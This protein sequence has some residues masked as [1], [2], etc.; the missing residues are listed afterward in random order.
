MTQSEQTTPASSLI[1][2]VEEKLN[3]N[4]SSGN[5]DT[6]GQAKEMKDREK[7]QSGKK[8]CG[9]QQQDKFI[10]FYGNNLLLSIKKAKNKHS[11]ETLTWL[12]N[13][14][15]RPIRYWQYFN[16]CCC[17]SYFFFTLSWPSEAYLIYVAW[18]RFG[19]GCLLLIYAFIT[20]IT[21]LSLF[22]VQWGNSTFFSQQ[23]KSDMSI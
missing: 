10:L 3:P 20:L 6:Q 18:D 15:I 5:T 19:R 12:P 8:G 11:S 23:M 7:L 2:R 17:S 16:D 4:T 1:Y 9:E 21:H 14:A 22:V 13:K